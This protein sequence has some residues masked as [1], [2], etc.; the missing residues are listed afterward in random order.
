[1][2][3]LI[4]TAILIAAALA[5]FSLALVLAR[6]GLAAMFRILPADPRLRVISGGRALAGVGASFSSPSGSVGATCRSPA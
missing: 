1:M 4:S 3:P 6:L 5:S 2:A